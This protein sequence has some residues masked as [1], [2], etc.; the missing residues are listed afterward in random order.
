[1]NQGIL[2]LDFLKDIFVIFMIP[3]T[4]LNVIC[5]SKNLKHPSFKTY[6]IVLKY[7]NYNL[8]VIK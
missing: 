2:S 1:M 6:Q 4:E 3:D 8:E 7:D 5:S